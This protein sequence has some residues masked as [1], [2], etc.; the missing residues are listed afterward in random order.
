MTDTTSQMH[1][2]TAP[3]S[4][5]S[6][7]RIQ[8]YDTTLRDGTQ[9][10]GVAF[11]LADKLQIARK[12]DELGVD[13]I[14]GGYPLSNPKDEAFFAEAAKIDFAHAKV[15]AF[16]MTRRKGVEASED[17]GMQA[18]V[19]SGAPVVT[20][21]GKTWDL[22]VDEVLRVDR[23]ENLAMIRESVAFCAGEVDEVIYDAEHFFDGLKANPEYA[24]K[25]LSAAVEGGAS[26]L[27]LCDTNGGSLPGWIAEAVGQ[28]RE[29]LGANVELGIHTH[30]DGGLALANSL[31]AVEAGCTQVQG[32]INGIGERCGNVDLIEVIANLQLKMGRECL[33]GGEDKRRRLTEVSRFVYEL[34]NLN[35]VSN[36]PFVGSGAFAHKGGMHVHAVQRVTHSYEHIEPEQV[37]N[38]RRVLVSELSGASNIAATLG[39]K[40]DIEEDKELQRK[41]LARVQDL[42]NQGYQFEAATASFELLLHEITGERPRYWQLDHYR[43]VILKRQD[44]A[45]VTEAI[46]KLTVDGT[47]EHRVA[48]GDGPVNALDGA[49]RKCLADHY[50]QLEDVHLRDYKVRVV[51]PTAE[52]AAKVRVISEFAV[53]NPDNEDAAPRYF[54]TTGVSEN[55][56]EASWEAISDAFVYYL[57]DRDVEAA[58]S[59]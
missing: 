18:L 15:T 57:H 31:T 50:P 45:P 29:A 49:L 51:N 35:A 1:P 36:Q 38:E 41:V 21:V 17:V 19:G 55:I 2:A 8:I 6:Q 16:G 20:I 9:G 12:L 3:D 28:V 37:G 58:N 24:L 32:T 47:D 44:E 22:H 40:F 34:A 10:E 52:S 48:E 26:R 11:S 39:K 23:E 42:E 5:D 33:D 30:D 4:S 53:I 56:V 13:Y 7:G 14:E 43:C 59:K 25:T 46:V 54:S 27:V